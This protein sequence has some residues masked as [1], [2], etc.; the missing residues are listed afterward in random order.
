M[1]LKKGD[2]RKYMANRIAIRIACGCFILHVTF[3]SCKDKNQESELLYNASQ[4]RIKSTSA[5]RYILNYYYEKNNLLGKSVSSAGEVTRWANTDSSVLQRFYPDNVHKS[6][7]LLYILNDDGLA[8]MEKD[9][10]MPGRETNYTYNADGRLVKSVSLI[11]DEIR[12]KHFFY[13]GKGKLDSTILVN[14]YVDNRAD[15]MTKTIFEYGEE[16]L[17]TIAPVN[18]GKYFLGKSSAYLHHKEIIFNS[19]SKA[20][21]SVKLLQYQFDEQG[22]VIIETSI[23]GNKKD[24]ILYEYK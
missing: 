10:L 16:K 22:R 1:C 19:N 8:M 6:I 4:H 2:G 12:E 20:V 17:N 9:L 14:K 5:N 15:E 24:T 13:S 7:E 23:S 18:F 21:S 11:G 3:A